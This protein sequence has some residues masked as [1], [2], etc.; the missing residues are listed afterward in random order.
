MHT[1]IY[2][3]H[4]FCNTNTPDHIVVELV[5]VS[6]LWGSQ[7]KRGILYAWLGHWK[8]LHVLPGRGT[9]SSLL[10]E[11]WERKREIR[12]REGER[13]YSETDG[14]KRSHLVLSRLR[15]LR[16]SSPCLL[17]AMPVSQTRL[18]EVKLSL[19]T[20]RE[21]ITVRP[22]PVTREVSGRQYSTVKEASTRSNAPGSRSRSTP[23]VYRAQSRRG[24]KPNVP[25]HPERNGTLPGVPSKVMARTPVSSTSSSSSSCTP[26]GHRPS[27]PR[28]SPSC[29]LSPS[30]SMKRARWLSYSASNICFNN[31][32]LDGRFRQLQGSILK[33]CFHPALKEAEG[34]LSWHTSPPC[35][36]GIVELVGF[37][38]ENRC[39]WLLLAFADA[40]SVFMFSLFVVF[41]HFISCA[42]NGYKQTVNVS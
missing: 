12:G 5:C 33:K 41:I 38:E 3:L 28:S 14:G 40:R 30:R 18:R 13:E 22:T 39:A 31:S 17:R 29:P 34:S 8:P 19:K 25:E 32:I 37:L 21:T 16:M 11:E 20:S 27:P 36:R 42:V 2:T 10:S 9:T 24:A 35:H 15:T 26:K 23:P 7:K 4:C 6:V 1:L